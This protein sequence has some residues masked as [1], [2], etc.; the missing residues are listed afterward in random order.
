MTESPRTRI[1]LRAARALLGAYLFV[2]ACDD[3]TGRDDDAE[4]TEGAI[5]G[6]KGDNPDETASSGTA[7]GQDPTVGTS[8]SGSGDDGTAADPGSTGSMC[9]TACQTHSDCCAPFGGEGVSCTSGVDEYLSFL[10][11]AGA[12]RV[13]S[14]HS[15]EECV[16]TLGSSFVCEPFGR[17]GERTCLPACQTDADCLQGETCNGRIC[18][19]GCTGDEDCASGNVCDLDTG[20]CVIRGCESDAD[21]ETGLVCA[22]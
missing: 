7:S 22:Q 20:I 8:A 4:D 13:G 17:P 19:S 3:D 12:C 14:C 16:D 1:P 10:C 9:V 11:E 2:P 15:D 5:G 21:C 18:T 6:S